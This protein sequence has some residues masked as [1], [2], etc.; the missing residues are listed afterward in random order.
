MEQRTYVRKKTKV[1]EEG[2]L[3]KTDSATAAFKV[4]YK[5]LLLP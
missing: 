3:V 4:L 1:E 5:C 2:D